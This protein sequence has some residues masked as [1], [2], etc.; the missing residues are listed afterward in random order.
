MANALGVS[1]ASI[2][3]WCDKGHIAFEKTGGGHRR[4][5]LLKAVEFAKA[6]RFKV[7]SNSIFE[8]PSIVGTNEHSR[9]KTLK[10]MREALLRGDEETFERLLAELDKNEIPIETVLDDYLVPV[11]KTIGEAWQRH[12][13]DVYQERRAC[14]MSIKV[15][16]RLEKNYQTTCAHVAM[17]ASL[18]GDLYDLPTYFVE[19][20]FRKNGWNA[21]S[22]GSNI[23]V[24]SFC[25]AIKDHQPK[26][27]WLSV[28]H[29]ED[30]EELIKGFESIYHTSLQNRT[31]LIAG[32]RALTKETRKHV[33]CG[34][35]FENLTQLNQFVRAYGN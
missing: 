27:A 4:I 12:E 21:S 26:I 31:M 17:G 23:T 29:I 13:A 8:L 10:C 32:G 5:P 14:K 3:R 24:E 16:S 19:L 30:M 34:A 35:Y 15:L 6:R 25:N 7:P 28:S 33:P 11:F 1:E 18:S 20:V 22:L 2:K 9:N